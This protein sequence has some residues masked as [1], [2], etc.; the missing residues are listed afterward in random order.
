M[1]PVTM[2]TGDSKMRGMWHRL[3][4]LIAAIALSGLSGCGL[5]EQ[6]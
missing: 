6:Q 4:I 5:F 3:G 2:Q 1:E